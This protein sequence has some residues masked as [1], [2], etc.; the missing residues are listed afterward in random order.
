MVLYCREERRGIATCDKPQYET[1]LFNI[2]AISRKP[3]TQTIFYSPF[4]LNNSKL[5]NIFALDSVAAA[6]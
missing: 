3:L 5:F 1:I 6:K 4:I 2:V